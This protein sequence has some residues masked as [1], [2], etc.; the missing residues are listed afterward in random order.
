MPDITYKNI[1]K[2]SWNLTKKNKWLWVYG[3]AL[4]IFG[5]GGSSFRGGSG[6][7]LDGVKNKV[8]QDL[9]DKEQV[10]GAVSGSAS[11][12]KDWFF[13]KPVSLWVLLVLAL[14]FIIVV[15]AVVFWVA[16]SWAKAGLIYGMDRA[17][18]EE[19]VTLAD[20]SP[21][22]ISYIKKLLLFAF[23]LGGSFLFF[24]IFFIAQK[25]PI[26]YLFIIIL[27]LAMIAVLVILALMGI[28]ADRL[29]VLLNYEPWPAWK[30][31]FTMVR[32][33]FTS[34]IRMGCLNQLFGCAAG[35]LTLLLLGLLLFAP[36]AAIFVPIFK[37]G[38]TVGKFLTG[39]LSMM[40]FLVVFVW[41]VYLTKAIFV[42]FNYGNWNL[43]FRQIID[44]EG[45]KDE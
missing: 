27:V 11:Q 34:T 13:A 41:A 17:D 2:R 21:T 19:E 44:S 36:G 12:V 26:F 10:L 3:L 38:F 22:A 1:I 6:G 43:F 24:I 35:C 14:I 5:G 33:N 9:P 32:Q 23:F 20:T 28:Y 4:A 8:P 45:E 39:A 42:V 25:L 15:F 40:V 16:R 7:R 37:N 29:I 18:K 30:R 31:S